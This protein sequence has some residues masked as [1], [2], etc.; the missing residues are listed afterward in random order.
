MKKI[1]SLGLSV[2][3][4]LLTMIP[5]AVATSV[6]KVTLDIDFIPNLIFSTYDVDL[7]LNDLELERLPHGKDYSGSFFVEEGSNTLYFYEHGS[8][9]VNGSLKIEI[10][11][12]T[13]ISC[14]LS[15]YNNKID[16]DKVRINEEPSEKI[17]Q[18]QETDAPTQA[19]T[20]TE[21]PT[22]DPTFTTEPTATPERATTE[23]PTKT[24]IVTAEPTEEPTPQPVSFSDLDF[25]SMTDEELSS[26]LIAIKAEQRARIKTKIVLDYSN[27]SIVVGKT[28]KLD[29]HI[30]ELPPEEEKAPKLEWS[31]SDSKI[32][33]VTNGTVKAVAGGKATIT[34]SATL[35][36]GTN[37]SQECEVNVI[38]L[39]SSLSVDNK[40]V[41]INVDETI[42]PN[43]I[44]KPDT[45]SSKELVFASSD[46][47][48]ATVDS[49]GTIK[50][51]WPGKAKI[52]ANTT[53]GSNRTVSIDVKVTYYSYLKDS[54]GK[55][56]FNAVCTNSSEVSNRMEGGSGDWYDRT[57][58]VDGVNLEVNSEGEYGRALIITVMD[59]M[60]TG[61]KETYYRV[62]NEVFIGDDLDKA[63]RWVKNNLGKETTTKIGDTNIVLR[64]TVMKTP[65]MYL[66]DDEHL[67]WI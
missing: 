28:Q 39:A 52:T 48:V 20:A 42:K 35:T 59:M 11:G 49:T 4:F 57:A 62:L 46:T 13:S 32:A 25:Q 41:S 30:E 22:L 36:D 29:A 24:P 14:R 5:S 12:N 2:V 60:K 54:N 65:I 47:E 64:L 63:T 3:L 7:Y 6:Y 17:A 27:V 44:I 56:I 15:C 37:I 45:V 21:V 33:T 34:C 10:S 51:E 40:T 1:V 31:S 55:Q 53:D 19:P 50:G 16:I 58:D 18:T 38:V 67:D 43:Y 8:K 66:L 23:T 61:K 9:S 26:A